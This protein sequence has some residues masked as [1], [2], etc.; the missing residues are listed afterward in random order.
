MADRLTA[1]QLES[2]TGAMRPLWKRTL[3]VGGTDYTSRLLKVGNVRWRIYNRHP[4]KKGSL[5]TPI[6]SI[7]IDNRDGLFSVGNASGVFPTDKDRRET[8][9][10]VVVTGASP[11]IDVLDF[12]GAALEPFQYDNGRMVIAVEH[13]LAMS[14]K[15]F[16][17]T[18]DSSEIVDTTTT[19][20]NLT[21]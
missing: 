14:T 11:G 9:I 7:E 1:A 10:R 2:L 12:T 8:S 20:R 16:W 13:P 3:T 4:L 21:P 5:W 18:D 17:N 19:T 6:L 15:R